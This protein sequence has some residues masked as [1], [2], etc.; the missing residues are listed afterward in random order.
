MHITGFF[1]IKLSNDISQILKGPTVVAIATK[2]ET[3]SAIT[4]LIYEISKSSQVV[5]NNECDKRT[6]VQKTLYG[7]I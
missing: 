1:G 6:S 4:R 7:A 2:F 5:F 3:K